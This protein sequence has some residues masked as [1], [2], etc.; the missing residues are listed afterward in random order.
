MKY[1]DENGEPHTGFFAQ[2]MPGYRSFYQGLDSE[3]YRD[4]VRRGLKID[5]VSFGMATLYRMELQQVYD[6]TMEM[7]TENPDRIL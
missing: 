4:A 7:L 1:L 2:Q 6:I 5:K 3:Y